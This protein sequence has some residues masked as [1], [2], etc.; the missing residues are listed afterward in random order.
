MNSKPL[1]RAAATLAIAITIAACSSTPPPRVELQ[2]AE[3]ALAVASEQSADTH[4]AELYSDAQRKLSDAQALM[5]KKKHDAAKRLL[6]QA[7]IDA[8]LAAATSKARQ[9]QQQRDQIE[10]SIEALRPAVEEHASSDAY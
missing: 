2:H 6:E 10:A 4:A 8:Q 9:T 7:T 5:K 1:N 3:N